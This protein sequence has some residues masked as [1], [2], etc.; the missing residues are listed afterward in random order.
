M[1]FIRVLRGLLQHEEAW[2]IYTRF[3]LASPVLYEI[4]TL[5]SAALELALHYR[6]SVYECLYVA[7]AMREQSD[8]VTADQ[9]LV[10]TF[11]SVFP[12]VRL[13]SEWP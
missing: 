6:H 12:W 7:L 4:S 11:R 10:R 1:L 2:D 5:S 8:L 3:D 9:G 13:L